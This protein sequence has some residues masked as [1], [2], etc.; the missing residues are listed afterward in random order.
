MNKLIIYL[1]IVF[2]IIFSSCKDNDPKLSDL[3]IE[4]KWELISFRGGWTGGEYAPGTGPVYV[5][6][7]KTYQEFK[8]DT[9]LRSGTYKIV[10]SHYG[11]MNRE[12]DRLDLDNATFLSPFISLNNDW[13]TLS[14]DAADV[15]SYSYKRVK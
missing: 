8:G 7:K 2:P 11:I 3:N 1:A 14:F 12:G 13:L 10:K 6:T 5:F 9:L 15:P 4:G